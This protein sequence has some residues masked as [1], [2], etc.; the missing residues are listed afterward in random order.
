MFS[1]PNLSLPTEITAQPLS[2]IDMMSMEWENIG[3]ESYINI[4]ELQLKFDG[5]QL[6][7]SMDSP[8]FLTSGHPPFLTSS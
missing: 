1:D 4:C 7:K 3:E 5:A 2:D 6:S 8:C